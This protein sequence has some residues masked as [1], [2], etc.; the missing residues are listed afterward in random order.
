MADV[1]ISYSRR[2]KDFVEILYKALIASKYETWI[3]WQ[4]IMPTTEWWK[5]IESDIEAAHTFI[6]VVSKDSISS[7]YC[8][9]EIDHAIAHGK[10]LIPI[11][12][13]KDYE[14]TDM[15]PKLGTHQWL[16]F[17]DEDNFDTAFAQLLDAINIDLAYKKVHTRLET[18]AVEWRQNGKDPSLMLQGKDLR[19]ANEWLKANQD[20][21]PK[22]TPLQKEYVSASWKHLR[23][24]RTI[25]LLVSILSTLNLL[26]SIFAFYQYRVAAAALWESEEQ[27]K[28][29]EAA[30]LESELAQAKLR[31]AEQRRAEAKAQA[32]AA[33]AQ[34]RETEKRLREAE[35]RGGAVR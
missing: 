15:H 25:V 3:D 19:K 30:I 27:R 4:D 21:D 34:I 14:H 16:M 8:R 6:F 18:R 24:R 10:R 28:I 13:R 1:F 22:P 5:E 20:Q 29:A 9:Q 7:K 12:R 26:T 17:R 32:E 31:E 11:L 2:D 23:N 33:A 35:T